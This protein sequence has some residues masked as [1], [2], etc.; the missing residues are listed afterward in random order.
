MREKRANERRSTAEEENWDDDFE[1]GSS[2]GSPVLGSQPKGGDV[3]PPNLS[4][5]A[6]GRRKSTNSPGRNGNGFTTPPSRNMTRWSSAS[7]ECWDD[8]DETINVQVGLFSVLLF[9]GRLEANCPLNPG[10]CEQ[11]AAEA[12]YSQGTT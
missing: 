4:P 12:R 8:E 1:F 10:L 9:F 2:A 6:L 5:R 11:P 7:F 3:T